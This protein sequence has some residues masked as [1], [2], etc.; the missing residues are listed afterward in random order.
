LTAVRTPTLLIVGGDEDEVLRLN[1]EAQTMLRRESRLTIVPGATHLFE[2]TG[3]L[4]I[5]AGLA[6][7]WFVAHL[8]ASDQ[9]AANSQ[10]PGER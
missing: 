10:E 7:E 1:R 6:R 2:E 8:G 9:R 5:V 3:T 4:E